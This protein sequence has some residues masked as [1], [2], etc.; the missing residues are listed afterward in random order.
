MRFDEAYSG[1]VFI[2]SHPVFEESEAVLYGMPMDWTVSYRPGSRFGPTRIREVSIGLEEYSPYL[3][4]ELE[5][6]KY[7]DAGDIPLPFGNP[8]RSLNMIEEYID[9]LL[10]ADKFPLGMG[11]EHLVSWPV[12]KAMYKKY[13]DLA[14]IHMDAHTDLREEY[15][16]EPLSHS[17]PIRK[18]AELIG[19]ENVYSFGIRS[20]MKEEFQWAK[21]NGMHISK[22]EVLEPLKEIL[23]T[24]A[25]RPVYVTIDIDVLDPA[26]AP[27]TGTV[28]AGGITSKELLAS[29]HAI[30]KSD[31][32]IVGGDLV[33]VA[34]IY[35]PS[36]Q[37][38]NT[39]SKLIREMILGWVQKK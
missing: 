15:E 2:G 37:T 1:N 18:V 4:R 28:D 31:L 36:E 39:A 19:P 6:V 20:G 11:G 26:H 8:Q 34:P 32:R 16:G 9:Q 10:A 24:L 29:I 38:A 22:F 25:G 33:E 21:E 17:T 12:M 5:E 3:D 35:D 13:P 14:I 30:A 27:G 7:F 23:P